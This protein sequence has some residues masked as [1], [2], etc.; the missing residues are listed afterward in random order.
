MKKLLYLVTIIFFAVALWQI[1]AVGCVLFSSAQP[2]SE[3]TVATSPQGQLIVNISE[4]TPANSALE[5][6]ASTEYSSAIIPS[7][8][9]EY[10][11][12]LPAVIV[13]C[14]ERVAETNQLALIALV[15]ATPLLVIIWLIGWFVRKKN[16]HV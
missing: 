4:D 15:Y 16:S 9:S 1:R 10:I 8:A 6:A 7:Q 3:E 13:R 11:P 5:V 14:E 2:V 12:G